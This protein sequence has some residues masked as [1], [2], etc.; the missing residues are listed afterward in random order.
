MLPFN[1][2]VDGLV[3]ILYLL[4]GECSLFGF[5][6]RYASELSATMFTS[7]AA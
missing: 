6:L 3:G 2:D 5:G 7:T 1:A 4:L